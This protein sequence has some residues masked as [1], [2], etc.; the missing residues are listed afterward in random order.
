MIPAH[1]FV[2]PE[3]NGTPTPGAN[4]GRLNGWTTNPVV[5]DVF[6]ALTSLPCTFTSLTSRP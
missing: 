1:P 5:H 3:L 2:S 4:V 6:V